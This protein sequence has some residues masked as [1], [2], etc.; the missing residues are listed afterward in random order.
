MTTIPMHWIA[1]LQGNSGVMQDDG[2]GLHTS[3]SPH[4]PLSMS[5]EGLQNGSPVD[6]MISHSVPSSHCIAVHGP[7]GKKS[8]YALS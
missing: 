1:L 6:G 4:P 8:I 2:A 3:F 7:V 5:H